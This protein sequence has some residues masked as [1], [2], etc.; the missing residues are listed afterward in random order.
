VLNAAVFPNGEQDIENMAI[1][2]FDRL[3]AV[4]LRGP[5][6][7]VRASL[8]ALK[9]TRGSIVITSS[10]VAVLADPIG[11]AYGAGKAALLNLVSSLAF[12][13]GENGIRINAVCPGPIDAH[14]TA[15]GN[16]AGGKRFYEIQSNLTALGRWAKPDEVAAVMDFLISEDASFVTGST[17]MVD[18]GWSAG[19]RAVKEAWAALLGGR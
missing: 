9:E 14:G 10:C 15:G 16:S 2:E 1:S 3:V 4:N 18:G 7:G 19:H 12:D 11:W 13:L 8:S 5:V 17:I 6:L